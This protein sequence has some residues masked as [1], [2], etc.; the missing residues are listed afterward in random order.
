MRLTN[1][2]PTHT[3]GHTE[4][5]TTYVCVYVHMW[6]YMCMCVCIW[7]YVCMWGVTYSH[8]SVAVLYNYVCVCVCVC[9]CV[10]AEVYY[11]YMRVGKTTLLLLFFT[12]PVCVCVCVHRD[13][14]SISLTDRLCAY[15]R[16]G[17][18][19]EECTKYLTGI[20]SSLSYI[21]I[22]KSPQWMCK[23]LQIRVSVCK[24]YIYK[25]I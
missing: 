25:Y 16:G 20:L 12:E 24:H 14:M 17:W 3:Y 9:V 4:A 11:V 5:R 10:R 8:V 1:L 22:V 13:Q 21:Y 7:V 2:I 15:V 23:L 19:L 6:I 18:V